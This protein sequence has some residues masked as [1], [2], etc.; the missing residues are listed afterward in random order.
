MSFSLS[1]MMISDCAVPAHATALQGENE[2]L[3]CTQVVLCLDISCGMLSAL[4]V[5]LCRISILSCVTLT[6]FQL[7]LPLLIWLVAS[8]VEVCKGAELGKL[9]CARLEEEA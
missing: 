2:C 3:C 5:L 9:P 4:G 7:S 1:G 6:G 8:A